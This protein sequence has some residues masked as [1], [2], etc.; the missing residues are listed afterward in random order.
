MRHT[1]DTRPQLQ[2]DK[3]HPTCVNK[4][5]N[6]HLDL[7]KTNKY[8]IKFTIIIDGTFSFLLKNVHKDLTIHM[9]LNFHSIDEQFHELDKFQH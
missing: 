8:T 3:C 9:R 5:F 4:N 2:L 1:L 6:E 7:I